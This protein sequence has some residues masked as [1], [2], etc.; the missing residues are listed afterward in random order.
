MCIYEEDQVT[1][2]KYGTCLYIQDM[3]LLPDGR[4]FIKT[5]G[6]KRFR[7]TDRSFRDGYN[8]AKVYNFLLQIKS[9]N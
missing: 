9:S 8:V 1:Y 7:I 2:S 4:S 6:T 5:I 3:N